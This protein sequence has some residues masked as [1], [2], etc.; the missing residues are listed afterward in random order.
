MREAEDHLTSR[1]ERCPAPHMGPTPPT[2]GRPHNANHSSRPTGEDRPGLTAG[3]AEGLWTS[4]VRLWS[5]SL[6]MTRPPQTWAR[7]LAKEAQDKDH[8]RECWIGGP[9]HPE[10]LRLCRAG[11]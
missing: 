2:T 7:A 11:A 1:A 5:A 3:T 8:H 4:W 9:G 6:R 10:Q